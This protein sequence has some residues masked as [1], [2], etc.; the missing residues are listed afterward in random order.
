MFPHPRACVNANLQGLKK[1]LSQ[2]GAVLFG[3][4]RSKVF[5]RRRVALAFPAGADGIAFAAPP[6]YVGGFETNDP[7]GAGWMWRK[8]RLRARKRPGTRFS[9][10]RSASTRA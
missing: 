5:R 2:T 10:C 7:E 3:G 9:N 1:R 4:M 6:R 8:I